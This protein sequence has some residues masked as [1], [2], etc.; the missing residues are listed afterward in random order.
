MKIKNIT[1]RHPEQIFNLFLMEV[2][3]CLILLQPD[4]LLIEDLKA[5]YYHNDH[6][7]LSGYFARV[8]DEAKKYLSLPF[9]KMPD[10]YVLDED[11]KV[12][13]VLSDLQPTILDSDQVVLGMP[14]EPLEPEE[15]GQRF[16]IQVKKPQKSYYIDYEL[17]LNS[18]TRFDP[19]GNVL[20]NYPLNSRF[21]IKNAVDAFMYDYV[22][23][24]KPYQV[25]SNLIL[26]HTSTGIRLSLKR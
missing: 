17:S 6:T 14:G 7:Y 3:N 5:K 26:Y 1:V 9:E 23:Y 19:N 18:L 21:E 10:E 12:V 11:C 25:P 24:K 16:T 8:V 4:S 22:K 13:K 20:M 15:Y 2:D